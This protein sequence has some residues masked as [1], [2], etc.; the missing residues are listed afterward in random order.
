MTDTTQELATYAAVEIMGWRF[1]DGYWLD[2]QDTCMFP[3]QESN[4]LELIEAELVKLGFDVR[5]HKGIDG[6]EI[7][8][9][10]HP[11]RF[12]EACILD[13][14]CENKIDQIRLTR[15]TAY[16]EA[17]RKKVEKDE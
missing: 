9:H 13:D 7:E 2:A 17:H 14:C 15:L 12:D 5:T 11:F 10:D 3:L 6:F 16:V 8:I 1:N 4:H